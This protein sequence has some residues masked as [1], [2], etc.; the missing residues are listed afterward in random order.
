MQLVIDIPDDDY[1]KLVNPYQH[2]EK[3]CERLKRIVMNGTPLPKG[4]GRLIDG[5]AL[6]NELKICYKQ[7]RNAPTIIPA[8]ISTESP[9]IYPNSA[10]E[11]GE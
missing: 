5:D 10:E 7:V 6:E 4:H 3:W 8:E 9:S 2:N 1:K 11:V